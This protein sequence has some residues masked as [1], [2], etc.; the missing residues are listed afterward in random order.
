MRW[1]RAV[2]SL[3]P[4]ALAALALAAPHAGAAVDV[5]VPLKAKA[6][7]TILPEGEIEIY[8]FDADAG[9]VIN[10]SISPKKGLPLSMGAILRG[11]DGAVVALGEGAVDGGKVK[12]KGVALATTGSYVLRVAAEGTGEYSL[13]LSGKPPVKGPK[14]KTLKLD[15]RGGSLGAPAGGETVLSRIVD[16]TGGTVLVDDPGSDLDGTSVDVPPGAFD[17]PTILTIR[18]SPPAVSPVDDDRQASGPSVEFGP[19]G[20]TFADAVTV[21]LPYDLASVPAGE[22]PQDLKV[23]VVEDDGSSL[24][25]NPSTVDEDARTV[26]VQ[27]TSF[28]VCV[29][30][31]VPGVARIG[32]DPGGDEYWL[33]IQGAS[34]QTD[35]SDDSRAREFGLF[36]GEVSLYG[37]GTFQYSEEDRVI[38]WSDASMGSTFS[39]TAEADS[40]SG[41]YSYGADGQSLL[42]DTGEPTP[43][44]VRVTR[45]ARYMTGR[46]ALPGE[47]SVSNY[48]FLRKHTDP[49]SPASLQGTWNAV[50]LEVSFNSTGSPDPLGMRLHRISGAFTFDG[51]GGFGATEA[52]K[53]AEFDSSTGNWSMRSESDSGG[54]TYAV[55]GDG[56]ALLTF[57]PEDPGDTGDI[58]RLFPGDG[59]DVMFAVD[60]Q[61][62]GDC[63]FF[64]ALVRQSEDFASSLVAGNYRFLNM[65]FE[66]DAFGE[67]GRF[68]PDLR[69]QDEE[70]SVDF[71]SNGTASADQSHHSIRRD[72]GVAGGVSV[73]NTS[74]SFNVSW[75]V[76]R[77]GKFAFVVPGENAAPVGF[78]VPG[79]DFGALGTSTSS[80]SD[81]FLLGFLLKPP[82]PRD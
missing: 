5:Q 60:D 73:E 59:L 57:P 53:K 33:L 42:F 41:T 31:S 25:V 20:A 72:S 39:S 13:S 47:A 69:L 76:D 77:K 28:S 81:D 2:R 12:A 35:G 1:I 70:I 15:L 23:L 46:E 65:D 29:P 44:P 62:C 36:V 80:G 17:G 38:S 68:A 50:G 21:T 8:R 19:S 3:A 74:D 26:T 4:A 32:L 64:I 14:V 9:T 34:M 43:L 22:D 51:E 49:L 55:Q 71:A 78:L 7:G 79:G 52:A 61:P 66:P 82:P 27:T 58:L 6:R 63:T 45:D 67:N 16:E 75:T 56:T 40:G 11:P 18:S 48:L 37:D 54:G 30:I 10:L 24:T